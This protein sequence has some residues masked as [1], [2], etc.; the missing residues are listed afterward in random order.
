MKIYIAFCLIAFPFSILNGQTSTCNCSYY[1]VNVETLEDKMTRIIS[2]AT[3]TGLPKDFMFN[4]WSDGEILMNNDETLK[5]KIIHYDGI[6]DQLFE[7]TGSNSENSVIES[8]TIKGFFIQDLGKRYFFKR[9]KIKYW[10]QPDS[11]IGYVQVLAEGR[12]S[13]YVHRRI[14]QNSS[15]T[16]LHKAYSYFMKL[17]DG[18]LCPLNANRRSFLQLLPE[19]KEEFKILLKNEHNRCKD[20]EQLARAVELYNSG[21]F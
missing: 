13:L 5:N 17:P 8:N 3:I 20:D 11:T 9:V 2:N 16:Q 7:F 6:T 18:K 21:H 10:F 15:G 1:A 19:K 12:I 4:S 14:E